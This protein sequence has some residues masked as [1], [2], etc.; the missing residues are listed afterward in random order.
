MQR[1]KRV[2]VI[3]TGGTIVSGFRGKGKVT[4]PMVLRNPYSLNI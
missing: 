1:K 3:F 2:L 4:G